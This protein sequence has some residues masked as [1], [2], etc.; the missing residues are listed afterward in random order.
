[1]TLRLTLTRIEYFCYRQNINEV[2][3]LKFF[4]KKIILIKIRYLKLQTRKFVK[5]LNGG[6]E[7]EQKSKRDF[8]FTK[9]EKEKEWRI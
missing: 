9:L 2:T 3:K 7:N 1:M 4:W 6:K 8:F 5:H